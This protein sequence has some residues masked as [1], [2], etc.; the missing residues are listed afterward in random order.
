MPLDN[1]KNFARANVSTGYDALT[2]SIALEAGH[3]ARL[4][5]VPFNATW[6]NGTDYLVPDDDPNVEVI[7][8]TAKATDTLTISRAQEGTTA[9]TKNTG[10][11]SYKLIAGLT[12]KVINEDVL[13]RS[14]DTMTGPLTL[15]ASPAS[16]LHAANKGYVDAI[17]TGQLSGTYLISSFGAAGT[18]AHTIC[19]ITAGTNQLFMSNPAT[20]AVGHGVYIFGA[21]VAGAPLLSKITAIAGQN[22]TIADNAATTVAGAIVQ[23]DDTVAIQSA[24]NLL[25]NVPTLTLIFDSAY[26]R[27]NGPIN[28]A[29]N[30][31]LTIPYD[32]VFSGGLPRVLRMFGQTTPVAD[33]LW[34]PSHKGTVINCVTIGAD[35]NSSILNA[36]S[37]YIGNSF[38]EI[39]NQVS[40][41]T[42]H[43]K[44]MYFRTYANP[45]ISGIDLWMT[46]NVLLEN[47]VVDAYVHPQG[48]PE[49]TYPRFGIRLPRNCTVSQ[50]TNISVTNYWY[51]IIY[52]DLWVSVNTFIQRCK[53]ACQTRGHDYPITGTILIVQCPTGFEIEGSIGFGRPGMDCHVR[54]EETGGGFWWS[55]IAGR[56]VYDPTN[57]F[58]GQMKYYVVLPGG[59]GNG[60]PITVTGCSKLTLTNLLPP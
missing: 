28:P 10:G 9:S 55:P 53:V 50:T 38:D 2:T 1:A 40:L 20:F 49:P 56:Y 29:T 5:A 51:G 43:I 17:A 12:A 45:Q 21:G 48:A 59:T 11:K 16:P 37:P 52:S 13:S 23:H 54:F 6:W 36:R 57:V 8:V 3:G 31:V 24:L 14:G 15:Y 35:M 42:V 30:S 7:R 25:T 27:V 26:Y 41:V 47:V 46:W 58:F 19:N 39:F 18:D 22:F 33:V 32:G 34:S 44:D 60:H 4:P